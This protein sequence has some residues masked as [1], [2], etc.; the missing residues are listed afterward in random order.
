MQTKVGS[1]L[2]LVQPESSSASAI[3]E[4]HVLMSMSVSLMPISGQPVLAIR[5]VRRLRVLRDV[6]GMQIGSS[7][8]VIDVH[9]ASSGCVL[10]TGGCQNPNLGHH[11]FVREMS[12][13]F[14]VFKD[15]VCHLSNTHLGELGA[16][17][18][19]IKMNSTLLARV[20][21]LVGGLGLVGAVAGEVILT[22]TAV[23]LKGLVCWWHHAVCV[24]RVRVRTQI[25]T[26]CITVDLS[27]CQAILW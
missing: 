16:Y 13:L 21:L 20:W 7:L 4:C 1:M 2:L 9:C 11:A 24:H 3:V 6:K 22:T 17:V 14:L 19:C 10:L 8:L 23:A 25:S 18:F 27:I 12:D 15:V 26:A 5:P